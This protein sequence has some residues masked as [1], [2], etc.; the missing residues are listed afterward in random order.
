[1]TV[2]VLKFK[3]IQNKNEKLFKKIKNQTKLIFL[4]FIWMIFS[5]INLLGSVFDFCFLNRI[6]TLILLILILL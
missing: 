3:S 2:Q 1:M 4:D 6:A 5:K